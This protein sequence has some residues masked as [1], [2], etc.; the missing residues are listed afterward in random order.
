MNVPGPADDI[1][2]KITGVT[3][4]WTSF[5]A[6]GSFC[7]YLLGY[8]A[9]RFQLS[10]Y[11]VATNLDVWDERYLF[12]G[13]RF[14]VYLVSSVPNVLLIVIV[15]WIAVFLLSRVLPVHLRSRITAGVQVWA[16]QPNSLPLLGTL[17]AVALI[18]LVMRKCF[19]LGNLLFRQDLHAIRMD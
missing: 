11:G 4:K 8:L 19:V 6:F 17:L 15:V 5:T 2:S 13:S 3:G 9:L 12:A 18:Q 1:V 10:A 14:L 16:G 7:V